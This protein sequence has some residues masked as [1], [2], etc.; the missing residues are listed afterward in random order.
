VKYLFLAI[1]FVATQL[2]V[3]PA[4][5]QSRGGG[6]VN[7]RHPAI[8]L[9][10]KYE[11]N[12]DFRYEVIANGFGTPSNGPIGATGP[13]G[14][15]FN[16]LSRSIGNLTEAQMLSEVVGNWSLNA[17]PP[18]FP[19]T[20]QLYQFTIAPFIPADFFIAQPTIVRPAEGAVVPRDFVVEWKWPD[21]VTPPPTGQFIS[22]GGGLNA[23]ENIGTHGIN[24][25]P[26]SV[27]FDPGY[28]QTELQVRAGSS[29]SL[30]HLVSPVTS[31][32]PSPY[33]SF[34]VHLNHW[35]AAPVVG[36]TVL[37][38]PEPAGIVLGVMGF[39]AYAAGWWGRG[40]GQRL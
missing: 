16:D 40:R 19:P 9:N 10:R 12:G 30:D 4:Q 36:V 32:S 15:L 1:A 7:R 24:S 5:A 23:S 29:Q 38:V 18:G 34:Q 13:S 8:I 35:N 3:A 2:L 27:Q 11:P 14:R 37:N 21:G 31:T 25:I 17:P 33:W 26:V 22:W 28:T 20:A 39:L 6:G